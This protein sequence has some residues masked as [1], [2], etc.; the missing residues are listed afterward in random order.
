ME[1]IAAMTQNPAHYSVPAAAL[2]DP[3]APGKVQSESEP[4]DSKVATAEEEHADIGS[5]LEATD[6]QNRPTAASPLAAV[7][8][9]HPHAPDW[10]IVFAKNF[11]TGIGV[12]IGVIIVAFIGMGTL[13]ILLSILTQILN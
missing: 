5:A 2:R 13:L 3:S 7:P 1:E 8:L 4:T 10:L 11:L 9:A 12:I 6:R